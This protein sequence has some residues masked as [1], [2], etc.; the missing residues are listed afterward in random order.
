MFNIDYVNLFQSLPKEVATMLIAMLP[1][2]ELRASIP[3]ALEVYKLPV[4]SA[5]FWSVVGDIVPAIF[6]TLYIGPIS[7]IL[8]KHSKA[9]A[10]LFNWWFNKVEKSFNKK[11]SR[12]GELALIIFVAIPLPIT[13]AWTGAVASFLFKVKPQRAV[14]FISS[15]VLI[16]GVIVTLI[17]LGMFHFF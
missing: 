15:G 6:I 16:S 3:I 11:H 12:Y 2:T 1:I 14:I 7:R 10:R 5:Y 17:S 13:G 4:W 8:S 9:F